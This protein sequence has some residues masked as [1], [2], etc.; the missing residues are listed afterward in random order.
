MA[1]YDGKRKN[2]LRTEW[3]EMRIQGT[4]ECLEQLAVQQQGQF[5]RTHQKKVS[6]NTEYELNMEWKETRN[7]DEKIIFMVK[8]ER[9]HTFWLTNLNY[10]FQKMS[11]DKIMKY[12]KNN[13]IY[14]KREKKIYPIAVWMDRRIRNV[15]LNLDLDF[16]FGF[17]ILIL[18]LI[19]GFVKRASF[20]CL[21]ILSLL[22][23]VDGWKFCLSYRC[24]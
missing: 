11:F 5:I 16:D 23:K 17:W 18:I 15:E 1:K 12:G 20:Y 2:I 13:R 7:S 22:M 6:W 21:P 19:F 4:K 14:W 3:Q 9:V 10:S 24:Q 8:S